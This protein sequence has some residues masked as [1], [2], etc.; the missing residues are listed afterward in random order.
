MED[1]LLMF[2]WKNHGII[3]GPQ[4]FNES[5]NSALQPTPLILSKNQIRVFYGARN[6]DGVSSIFSV[7]L[8]V[9]KDNIEIERF[10]KDPLLEPGQHGAFDE[11]GVVPCFSFKD[12][13]SN[14]NLLYAG[15]SL[16]SK[17]RFVAFSGLAI[18]KENSEKYTR[19]SNSPFMERTNKDFLFRVIH[20]MLK[21]KKLF[22]IWY[23]AGSSFFEFNNKTY[24][25]Y[26]I[27]Y[28][29]TEDLLSLDED[30]TVVLN[31]INDEYRVGR[32]WVVKTDNDK[33]AMFFGYGSINNTYK[34]GL[35]KSIDALIWERVDNDIFN[36]HSSLLDWDNQMNAYPS[37]VNINKRK[38][39]FYNGNDY[40]K[41]GFGVSELIGDFVL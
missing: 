4:N 15:Y 27:K 26:N 20:C 29:E 1:Y 12:H 2:L 22:K 17:V 23:G 13:Q 40:G 31:T 24:P 30:G 11:N 9:S 36:F 8:I 32:P 35:A 37:F 10:S 3:W 14:I 21:E 25:K 41:M 16:P 19:F 38:L 28:L 39:L 34:I 5:L 6:S 7:D 33:Y 18:L